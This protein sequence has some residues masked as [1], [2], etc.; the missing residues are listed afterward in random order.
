MMVRP[1]ISFQRLATAALRGHAARDAQDHAGEIHVA[2]L[3]LVGQGVVERVDA[4]H[5]GEGPRLQ[6]LHETLDVARI[7]DEQ[8]A[9]AHS[10]HQHRADR[11]GED[12]IERQGRHHHVVGALAEERAHPR[13]ALGNVGRHIAVQQDSALGDAGSPPGILQEGDVIR[14]HRHRLRR[15][16]PALVEH[17]LEGHR[18]REA[19]GLHRLLH[20]AGHQVDDRALE[21][22]QI[23]GRNHHHLV[24]LELRQ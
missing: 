22:E 11:Q 5:Q 23:A 4:R 2:Q 17:G 9:G 6:R 15:R 10:R 1:V 8:L 7:G 24:E 20:A 21:A 14:L 12:V 19:I 13:F 16:C 3:G 18:L